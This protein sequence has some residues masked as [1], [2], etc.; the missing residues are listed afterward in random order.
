MAVTLVEVVEKYK[1]T[2]QDAAPEKILE[3]ERE[4]KKT[5]DQALEEY[6]LLHQHWGCQY[7]VESEHHGSP[8]GSHQCG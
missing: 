5:L 6:R 4:L 3:A 2:R 1:L 8:G 7:G